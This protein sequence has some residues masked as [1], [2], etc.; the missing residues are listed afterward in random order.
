MIQNFWVDLINRTI[1]DIFL[2]Q[3][4]A[5]ALTFLFCYKYDSWYYMDYFIFFFCNFFIIVVY[6]AS[7]IISTLV[8][9]A[10]APALAEPKKISSMPGVEVVA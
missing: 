7:Y 1:E 4:F 10:C 2:I 8:N 9:F 6:D 3:T 5:A